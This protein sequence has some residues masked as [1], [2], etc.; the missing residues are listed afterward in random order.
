MG[1]KLKSLFGG[2]SEEAFILFLIFILLFFGLDNDV[3]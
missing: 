1:L 3:C 2:D